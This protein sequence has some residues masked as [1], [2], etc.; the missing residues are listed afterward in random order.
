MAPARRLMFLLLGRKGAMPRLALQL[1]QAGAH[2]ADLDLTFVLSSRN[3]LIGDFAFLEDRLLALDTIDPRSP[4][5]T[6]QNYFRASR[7]IV[8]RIERDRPEVVIN[9]CPHVWTPLLVAPIR[10][11]GVPFVTVVHDATG[12]PGDPGACL[13]PWFRVETRA[14]NAV[15]TLSRFV[16]DELV[17]TR[18]APA[19][20]IMPLFLP[21]LTYGA[22]LEVRSRATGAPLRMLFFGRLL[23]YKG[24][25]L[26]LD[27]LE[28]LAGSGVRVALTVAGRGRVDA[29]AAARLSALGSEVINRWIDDAE[30]GALF[31]RHDAL[32]VSHLECSQSGIAASAFGSGLPVVGMPVG[33]LAGQVVEGRTGVLAKAADAGALADA[34]ARLAKDAALYA[35][36]CTHLRATAQE[37]STER[38]L[39]AL[40]LGRP[41]LNSGVDAAA[42]AGQPSSIPGNGS[43]HRQEPCHRGSLPLCVLASQ[44]APPPQ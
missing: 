18:A 3:D 1:A 38:F 35:A 34:I 27:A 43:Q 2:R 36:I 9:L 32:V 4:F 33:G 10:R 13:A 17:R 37:R 22:G 40:L 11:M 15:V 6:V 26:L 16:A 29:R 30:I 5:R 25:S 41:W 23:K 20:R 24:L 21:D 19:D 12:H 8:E 28:M 42:R 39:E 31:E 44:L 7:R 14:A